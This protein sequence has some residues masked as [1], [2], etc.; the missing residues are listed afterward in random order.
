MPVKIWNRDNGTLTNRVETS[1][2]DSYRGERYRS[3]AE[4]LDREIDRMLDRA[5]EL[6]ASVEAAEAEEQ[7]F[8]KRWAI[9]RALDESRLLQSKYLEPQETK[10]LWQAIARKCRLGVRADGS[11]EKVWQELT[12]SRESDPTRLERDVFAVGLWLQEQEVAPAIAAFGG[13]FANAQRFYTRQAIRSLKLREA[14]AAWIEHQPPLLRSKLSTTRSFMGVIKA[15]TARFPG[16]GPGSAKR[17]VHYSDEELYAEVCKVLDPIAA[18][19]APAN[20]EPVLN[21]P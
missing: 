9:G 17:P 14:L 20:A 4:A 1:R 12:P 15:L 6:S 5:I 21:A 10:A 18:E 8:I 16:R 13:R 2:E 19:L 7:A 3:D 11:A